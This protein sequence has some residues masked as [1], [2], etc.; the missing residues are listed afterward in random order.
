MLRPALRVVLADGEE[1]M[2]VGLRVALAEAGC[3]VTES[4]ADVES[5]VAAVLRDR[6]DVCLLDA[7]LPGGGAIAVATAIEASV[8][9]MRIVLLATPT[10]DHLILE[11]ISHQA[12]GAL[13]RDVDPARLVHAL[14]AVAAGDK[15]LPHRLIVSLVA[16]HEQR[17]DSGEAGLIGRL[18]QRERDVMDLLLE[19]ASTG[20]VAYRLG[21]AAVTVRRHIS[22]I[23]RKS[24]TTGRGA[25][26]MIARNERD[27][28]DRTR[29][30]S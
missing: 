23:V 11:M 30:H 22:G 29:V 27:A 28:H 18:T 14:R 9:E 13:P 4:A 5:A 6:P 1:A 21:V 12:H 8:G 2:R 19:D 10:S 24:G 16:S 17:S 7:L 25:A 26:V 3:I 20:E 15:I